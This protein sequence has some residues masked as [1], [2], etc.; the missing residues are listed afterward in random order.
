VTPSSRSGPADDPGPWREG[1][2]EPVW[3]QVVVGGLTSGTYARGLRGFGDRWWSLEESGEWKTWSYLLMKELSVS[4]APPR[5]T[6]P[7]LGSPVCLTCLA[8]WPVSGV[9]VCVPAVDADSPSPEA[10]ETFRVLLEAA[11][12][13]V[14]ELVGVEYVPGD[15]RSVSEVL[16][17]VDT[18]ESVASRTVDEARRDARRAL[19]LSD[20]EAA[21]LYPD[22]LDADP[23][24]PPLPPDDPRDVLLAD[25]ASSLG[26][27][28]RPDNGL[29]AAMLRFAADRCG[30]PSGVLAAADALPGRGADRTAAIL[31]GAPWFRVERG[32]GRDVHLVADGHEVRSLIVLDPADTPWVLA[33]LNAHLER[34]GDDGSS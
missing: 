12:R 30:R 7:S 18:I 33:A 23:D 21:D 3:P 14:A 32:D 5:A 2:R 16:R 25:V 26:V 6:D 4:P 1:D 28:Y 8:R 19:G 9:H 29:S 34:N 31:G 17:R 24:T 20:R 13:G 22:D 27:V 10:L 15:A 11:F